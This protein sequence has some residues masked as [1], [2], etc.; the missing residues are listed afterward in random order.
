[1]LKDFFEKYINN[2]YEIRS[3]NSNGKAQP[4][5]FHVSYSGRCHRMRFFKRAGVEPS[6][7][8]SVSSIKAMYVGDI[9]HKIVKDILH[10]S[11]VLYKEE[12][13]VIDDHRKGFIDAI[14]ETN[15]GLVIY[16]F[17]S[18]NVFKFQ[19]NT[20]DL[21]HAMQAY[22]YYLMYDKEPIV[23]VKVLYI[24]KDNLDMQEFNV[25]EIKDIDYITKKDWETLINYWEKHE[26]PPPVPVEN[27]ECEYCVFKEVCKK[28]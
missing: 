19:K 21:G 7:K 26:L 2:L 4:S 8:P 13:K 17:K 22:T 18:V 11:G 12:E 20:L 5:L 3:S 23:D 16:E 1:M 24:S 10:D 25:K 14:V 28:Y 15:E 27:W 6:E 9:Y